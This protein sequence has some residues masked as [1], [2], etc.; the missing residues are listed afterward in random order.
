[1]P[2]DNITNLHQLSN[3]DQV[4]IRTGDFKFENPPA[5]SQAFKAEDIVMLTDGM[6]GSACASFHESLKNIAGVQAIVVGGAPRLGPMETVGGS[7]GG[8]VI[9]YADVA[10]MT[11]DMHSL[12]KPLGLKGLEHPSIVNLAY[13]ETVLTRAGD[14]N[15]RLQV[16]DQLRKDDE[17]HTPLQFVYEAADCRLFYTRETLLHPEALWKAAWTAN[18]DRTKCVEGSTMQASSISGGYIPAGSEGN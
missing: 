14:G 10:N 2:I 4:A 18:S 13:P 15:S 3:S 12:A 5:G 16:Q 8:E 7:K 6:C 9:T 17:T 1:M 11:Q